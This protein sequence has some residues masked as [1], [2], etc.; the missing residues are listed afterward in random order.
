MPV[1]RALAGRPGIDLTVYHGDVPN[2]AN[3]PP[4]GFRAVHVPVARVRVGRRTALWHPPQWAL[5]AGGQADVL[6]LSW[7][8][9]YAGLVP[10]LLRAQAQGVPTILWGHGYSKRESPVRARLR[11]AVTRLATA[12]L[13]YDHR[14][15]ARHVRAGADPA[16]VFVAANALDGAPIA[17][18][19]DAW[20]SDPARLSRFRAG[21]GLDARPVVL[22]VSRLDPDNRVDLLLH[23][24]A[25]LGDGVQVAVIG[26]GPDRARLESLAGLLGLR[27]RVRFTGAIYDEHAV[28]PWFLTSAAFCYPANV[29][30]SL[31]HAF[32]YG[33]PVV[34]GD[35]L[36]AHNPEIAALRPDENGL[37]F[38]A[39]DAADLSRVLARL[40]ADASLRARLSTG[41]RDTVAGPFSL[42]RMVDGFEAAVRFC[43]RPAARATG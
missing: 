3:A 31:L 18:A 39:G 28:A 20:S 42:D 5:A 23:A 21:R 33:V 32:G 35:D 14:T 15:A 11:R 16:R 13:F 7:D 10:A 17:V 19:R 25:R 26:D 36:A 41:A 27:E 6:C 2:L 1:F 43:A 9:H 30:L 4:D 8:L 34:T 24:A 22:F 40:L 38:R 12:V 37:L 29:G